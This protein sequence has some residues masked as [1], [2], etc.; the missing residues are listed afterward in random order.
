MYGKLLATTVA[1]AAALAHSSAFAL[2]DATSGNPLSA[3]GV[4]T[5]AGV[6]DVVRDHKNDRLLHVGPANNK[7]IIGDYFE[8]G[9]GP[10]CSSY[11][12]MK[13]QLHNLPVSKAQVQQALDNDE[14]YSNYFQLTVA[15]P[16]KNL[17]KAKE[18]GDKNAEINALALENGA[19]IDQYNSLNSIWV[20]LA[21]DKALSDKEVAS[22]R[23][24]QQDATNMCIVT[25]ATD[26][27]RMSECIIAQINKF[28]PL[29]STA[30]AKS[31]AISAEQDKIRTDFYTVQGLYKAYTDKLNRLDTQLSFVKDLY[32]FQLMI[33]NNAY[34]LEKK[35]VDEA[36][37]MVAGEAVAGYNLFDDEARI[38]SNAVAG[39]GYEVRELSVFDIRL[40]SGVSK[41]NVNILGGDNA[42]LYRKNVWTYPANTV[43]NFGKIG[44]KAM[45]FE[46]ETV[47]D[48]VH[49][50]AT[51]W[52]SLGAGSFNFNV[53]KDARCG[54]Y[55]ENTERSYT[56]TDSNGI[57][58]SWTVVTD[59]YVANGNDAV[60][61]TNIGLTYNYYAYPG[62][63][64]GECSIDVDRMNSYWRNTGK[65]KGWSWFRSKTRSWDHIRESAR[66]NLGM[67]C[68]LSAVPE[69]NDP[70]EAA[71]LVEE[72][73]SQLY[74][75]MWQMFLATYAESYD[76]VVTDPEVT[77]A[78]Q[79]TVGAQLGDGLNKVC[80]R[81]KVCQVANV[82]L[83]VLDTI[84]GS[85]AQGTTSHTSTTYGKIWRRYS[86]ESFNVFQGSALIQAKVCVDKAS[87]K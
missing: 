9:G 41:E 2:P 16:A 34:D 51:T 12:N 1:V 21:A 63:I 65:S 18:I 3:I 54:S 61:A 33:A 75:D 60:F 69:S 23:T 71:R 26:P 57:K 17:K 30:Q 31:D 36:G 85:K 56:Y 73:E 68:S 25:N 79:S 22:L 58:D 77:D 29:I 4:A 70:V 81:N 24:Q 53:T 5:P 84:G 35:A 7:E 44:D 10:S 47:G 42:P 45:P 37:R 50:D 19:V 46:R 48:F 59:E 8:I 14:F 76:L 64:E 78:G 86:K 11:V 67:E 55:T 28:T 80:P 87:C 72:L 38:L 66:E 52:D 20:G 13:N 39:K 27:V 40:N 32:G 49:F 83:R 62:K 15:I 43:I 6:G 74:T 82:V